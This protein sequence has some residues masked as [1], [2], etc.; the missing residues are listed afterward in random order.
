LIRRKCS[1]VNFSAGTIVPGRQLFVIFNCQ[2]QENNYVL[3]GG[4]NYWVETIINPIRPAN[5]S[6][7]EEFA[8]YDFRKN[9]GQALGGSAVEN[10]SSATISSPLPQIKSMPKKKKVQGGC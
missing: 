1:G 7:N 2:T 3:Q 4:L 6:P 10:E 9:A 5:T 8:K